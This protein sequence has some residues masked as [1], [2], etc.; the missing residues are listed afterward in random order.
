MT[1]V[2]NNM[3]EFFKRLQDIDFNISV[4]CYN[5]VVISPSKFPII[6]EDYFKLFDNKVIDRTH[7]RIYKSIL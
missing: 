3:K 2:L 4:S 7:V 1:L 6:S 5:F